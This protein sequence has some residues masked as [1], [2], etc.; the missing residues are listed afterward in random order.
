M[1]NRHF[2]PGFDGRAHRGGHGP[3]GGEGFDPGFDPRGMGYMRNEFA[4]AWGGPRARRGD[5]RMAIIALLNEAPASG[6]GLIK[7]I[8]E[9]TEHAW[10][11]SPGSVYPTLQQLV[12]E[13]LAVQPSGPGKGD[14]ELTDDGRAY[15]AE[16]E[17]AI[18][19]VFA[20]PTGFPGPDREFLQSIGR[21]FDAVKQFPRTATPEQRKAA[22]EKMDELRRELYRILAD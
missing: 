15:A 11:P 16:H 7:A 12:D 21:L 8:A 5:V 22:T 14:Y 4:R 9:R 17:E 10:R 1:K 2:P 13:G 3:F 6:Y 20:Q 19:N 18:A